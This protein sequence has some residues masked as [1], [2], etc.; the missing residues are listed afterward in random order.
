MA[1]PLPLLF[2]CFLPGRAY[3]FVDILS[4]DLHRV[5]QDVY[6]AVVRAGRAVRYEATCGAGLPLLG[7]LD[8]MLGAGDE[9][10]R[11][12]GALSGESTHAKIMLTARKYVL[13]ERH[14]DPI[15][16]SE[17]SEPMRL[18]ALKHAIQRGPYLQSLQLGHCRNC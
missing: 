11:I 12:S 15:E 3:S 10:S 14:R 16:F 4:S 2:G 9:I 7:T 18:L 8:R 13:T 17:G 5:W 6:D 1:G